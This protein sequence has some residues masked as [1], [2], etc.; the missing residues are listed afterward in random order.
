MNCVLIGPQAVRIDKKLFHL[1]KPLKDAKGKH[2]AATDNSE[3]DRR[4]KKRKLDKE[5]RDK[6]D[7]FGGGGMIARK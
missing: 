5:K 7:V 1:K 4:A 6:D 2:P 3:E